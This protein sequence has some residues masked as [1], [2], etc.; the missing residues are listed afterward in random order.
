MLAWLPPPVLLLLLL[1]LPW[2]RWVAR[3]CSKVLVF[4]LIG[5]HLCVDPLTGLSWRTVPRTSSVG[6]NFTCA[7]FKLGRF[8][9][10]IMPSDGGTRPP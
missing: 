2:R 8:C 1:L 10:V 7:W 6:L 5:R 4:A 9:P 3:R